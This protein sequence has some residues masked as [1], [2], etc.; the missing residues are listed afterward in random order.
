MARI[1]ALINGPNLNLL[2]SRKPEIYGTVTLAEIVGLARD[3]AAALGFGLEDFQS[4]SEGAIIDAVQ[5]A[6]QSCAGLVINPGG[7]SFTSI[8]L[9]DAL[10]AFEI[11]KIEVHMSNIFRREQFRHHSFASGAVHGVIAGSGAQAYILAIEAVA[12]L[13]GIAEEA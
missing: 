2:G 11:P 6:G 7:Y 8:A 10:E 5:R 1:I 3:R 9:F 4:N 12:K 13:A